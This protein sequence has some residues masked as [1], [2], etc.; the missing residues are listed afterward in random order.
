MVKDRQVRRL[1]GLLTRGRP[2]RVASAS[3]GMCERT[4]RR[5]RDLGKLPSEVSPITAGGRG[6]TRLPTCGRKFTS[7]WKP[8]PVCR[9][10]RFS[11]GCKRRYPGRFQDGQFGRF[12]GE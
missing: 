10:R 5:Y 2:M 12:S 8:R 9:P 1:W 4:G 6:S 11:S 7:N 3:S